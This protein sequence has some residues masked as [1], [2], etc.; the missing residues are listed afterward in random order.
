M[1][2]A[3][4]APGATR[5]TKKV[6]RRTMPIASPEGYRSMLAAARSGGYALPAINVTSSTTILA[7]LEGLSEAGSDGIL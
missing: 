5:S 2:P 7:A 3:R 6:R 4:Y 1:D